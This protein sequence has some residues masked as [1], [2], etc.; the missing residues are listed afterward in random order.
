MHRLRRMPRIRKN[1]R[2][3]DLWGIVGLET[4]NSTARSIIVTLFLL[5]ALVGSGLVSILTNPAGPIAA[6]E[7]G[8]DEVRSSEKTLPKAVEPAPVLRAEASELLASP[9]EKA[10]DPLPRAESPVPL[11]QKKLIPVPATADSVAPIVDRPTTFGVRLSSDGLLPGRLNL[12]DPVS[13]V[14]KPT[15]N[16]TISFL[17]QGKVIAQVKPGVSG[18]FQVKDLP[19]G[20]YSMVATGTDGF[21]AMAVLV[22]PALT[23]PAEA[24]TN[25]DPLQIDVDIVHPVNVP[26]VRM[27]IRERLYPSG[28][29]AA[30]S[31]KTTTID[32]LMKE[33]GKPLRTPTVKL[34]ADGSLRTRFNWISPDAAGRTPANDSVAYLIRDGVIAAKSEVGADGLGRFTGAIAPGSYSLLVAPAPTAIVPAK[35]DEAVAARPRRGYGAMGIVVVAADEPTTVETRNE[36]NPIRLVSSLR[37]LEDPANSID[38]TDI[39]IVPIEDIEGSVSG[40]SDG[41]GGDAAGLAGGAPPRTAVGGAGGGGGGGSDLTPLLVGGGIA[42]L[43]AAEASQNSSNNGSGSGGSGGGGGDGSSP[44]AIK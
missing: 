13:G 40:S 6:S 5:G 31:A 7:R 44:K 39:D 36:Q 11:P 43:L 28:A 16:L 4:M 8:V 42:A 41:L 30:T 24:L 3:T 29:V 33:R 23:K 19:T 20:V 12:V 38:M 22:L 21:V 25:D 15:K 26:L 14:R 32:S 9:T 27:M 2:G 17:Q 10:I 35:D 37:R 18:V 1:P 34:T